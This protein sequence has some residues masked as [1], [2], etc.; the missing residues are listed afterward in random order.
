MH[1]LTR[2]SFIGLSAL[3]LGGLM[4]SKS[5][6][7]SSSAFKMD[8]SLY[9][10][11]HDPARKYSIRPFWFWNGDLKVEE[12]RTQMQQMISQGVYGAYAH[13]RDGLK[14]RYLSKEWWSVV[15]GALNAAE[16]LGFSLC[17]VDE[18]EWPSGEARDFGLPGP[19][20][21]LVIAANPAFHM[22]RLVPRET[23]VRS[24]TTVHIPLTG[25][26]SHVLAARVLEPGKLDGD[27]IQPLP[28]AQSS[29][30]LEWTAPAGNWVVIA[31]D[32]EK[33]YGNPDHGTVDLMNRDAVAEYIKIYY[34]ELKKRCGAH[35]GKALPATFADHE[36]TYGGHYPW[37]PALSSTFEQMHGYDFLSLLPALSYDIGAKTEKYRCDLL[38]TVSRLYTD[39]FFAQVTEW[40]SNN[41]LDHSAHVWEESLFLGTAYQGD[42]FS[43]LRALS[44]PGC[45]TLVEWSRQ[46]VW[47]KE[48]ASVAD[49]ERRHVVCENQGVQGQQSY[50][51]PER[52]RRT[53]NCLGAWNIGEFIPHA[54]NYDL[55]TT[56]FPPDWFRGQPFMPWFKDYADQM[57]RIS[58]MNRDSHELADIVLFYPQVSV[59]G[60]ANQIFHDDGISEVMR[61]SAWS[62]DAQQTENEY[63]LL[64]LR[65][66]E[67]RLAYQ[68]AD[69]HYL[70]NASIRNG[71][72]HVADSEFK[73]LILPPTST[74]HR[75]TAK[76]IGAFLDQGGRVIAISQLP[77]NSPEFGR[78]DPVLKDLWAKHFNNDGKGSLVERVDASFLL[79]LRQIVLCDCEI[80]DGP[81]EN[82]FTMRKTKDGRE[83]YWIVNDSAEVRTN[84]LRLR[85]VGK[86]ER[87]DA[88]TGLRAPLFYENQP[89][90]T[91]VRLKLDQWDAA[92]I[93]FEKEAAPQNVSL[94]S[95]N[96]DDFYITGLDPR[97][98]VVHATSML[99]ETAGM[100][101]LERDGIVYQG[102]L[103]PEH[104]KVETVTGP[105]KATID[106][107]SISIPYCESVDD[108]DD[109]GIRNHWPNKNQH[110]L[111][112]QQHWLSTTTTALKR[113]NIIGPFPNPEDDG[114]SR[115]YAPE[116]EFNVKDQYKGDEDQSIQWISIDQ[117]QFTI[118]PDRGE[119]GIGSAVIR[120]GTEAAHAPYIDFA[121]PL[122]MATP[123]GTVYAQTFVYAENAMDVNLLLAAFAPRAVFL[124][125]KEV[126]SHWLRPFYNELSDAFAE[127][128]PLSLKAGWNSLM[129]KLIN[130]PLVPA[131]GRFYC[132]LATHDG[133]VVANTL[134]STQTHEVSSANEGS[135]FR[136]IRITIPRLVD[137]MTKPNFQHPWLAF[138]DG[139]P[140]SAQADIDLPAGAQR[141]ILR[142]DA[143]EILAAPFKFRTA[144][145]ALELGTWMHL[146]LEH[147]SG[148]MTYE[149]DIDLT[150]EMLAEGLL[151]DCG[152]V[153]VVAEAWINGVSL[154]ARAWSPFVFNLSNHAH[155][156][157]NRLKVKIANTEANTR[158]VGTSLNL[159]E[160]IDIDGWEGPARLVPYV[161]KEITLQRQ[162]A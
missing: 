141:V 90:G 86:P 3:G 36:G 58:F 5:W 127:N 111:P 101:E 134:N 140:V 154:G 110:D 57:R 133:G 142:V 12:L 83:F 67:E 120:G 146:G 118:M 81:V 4:T 50:L 26:T 160:S 89:H 130:N 91:I 8:D 53:S 156:G 112:W 117:T 123:R 38:A 138:V 102:T 99:S 139:V 33:T 42:F 27:T 44:N 31:Y 11:F 161:S 93:V 68:V 135:H 29:T 125:G 88:Q 75:D 49:F 129:L 41:K 95:T 115:R 79:E 25:N 159:L 63:A 105:W 87:W 66:S 92:Y 65:L 45:D 60:Q 114:L 116:T 16:E 113:W 2:R 30:E 157:S 148:T 100:L 104:R 54:F 61:N 143:R 152:I 40:C 126:F 9:N 77:H 43:I 37:T 136:W 55:A 131:E 80:V 162:S 149:K 48:N 46:S 21:S 132:R 35:F 78:N 20:K 32:L 121:D 103:A 124:N 13:N 34:E 94:R 76:K 82:L 98:I 23:S 84:L 72:L 1:D 28:Q 6:A 7:L 96:L 18:F 106:A 70:Q 155:T 17:L 62:K 10:L 108:P 145:Q 150:N 64:K 24:G 137:R 109:V 153:G 73:L 151:L 15:Q 52:M 71:K 59:W 97:E 122:G 14:Q 85:S 107:P 22:K 128:I 19:Q 69:D 74:M 147:F 47:L 39:N 119:R 56:N 158:A 144:S 51:S